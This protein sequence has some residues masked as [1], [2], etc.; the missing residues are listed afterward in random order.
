MIVYLN[1]LIVPCHWTYVKEEVE[2]TNK[3]A[4]IAVDHIDISTCPLEILDR[5]ERQAWEA[6]F[7]IESPNEKSASGLL[8]L[9]IG[10]FLKERTEDLVDDRVVE[11]VYDPIRYE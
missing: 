3:I 4:L 2:E 1:V 7:K 6:L 5:T 8:G 11:R 9:T 10:D